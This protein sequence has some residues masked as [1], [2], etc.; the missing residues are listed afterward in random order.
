MELEELNKELMKNKTLKGAIL[1]AI[2]DAIV[3]C[4][5]LIGAGVLIG[6]FIL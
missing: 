1:K 6:K 3:K 2:V 4:I 5:I